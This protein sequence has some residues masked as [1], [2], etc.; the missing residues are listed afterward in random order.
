MTLKRWLPTFLAFPLGGL[1]AFET[2]GSATGPATAAAGGLLAGA[3]IGVGQWL[4]LR[5]EGVDRRWPLFTAAAMTA[6][7]ALAAAATGAGTEVSDLVLTGAVAG[8]AVGAAQSALLLGSPRVGRGHRGQLGA[9]V[10]DLGGRAG[11]AGRRG[12]RRLRLQRRAGRHRA[13]RPGAPPRGAR[14]SLA[15]RRA[16]RPADRLQRARSGCSRRA[17]TTPTS[18]ASPPTRCSRASATGGRSLVLLW[19]AF[20]LTALAAR[21]GGGAAVALDRRRRRHAAR[22]RRPSTGVL[23]ALV[24]FL[25]LVRWPFLVPYLARVAA[26]PGASEARREAVDVVFQAFNR[27]LGVAVGEHL[28]Y[29]LT[30]AW[31]IAR[32][33]RAHPDRPP[34][35]A[36]SASSASSSARCSRSARSSSSAAVRGRGWK[37]AERLTPIAYVAWSLWLIATGVALLWR[38]GAATRAGAEPG[39]GWCP[40]PAGGGSAPGRARRREREWGWGRAR[41]CCRRRPGAC[42]GPGPGRPAG[43]GRRARGAGAGSVGVSGAG[44]VRVVAAVV[45][46][47]VGGVGRHGRTRVLDHDRRHVLAR[48]G[49]GARG[50]LLEVGGAVAVGVVEAVVDAVAVGVGVSDGSAPAST[51][52][53][54]RRPSWSRVLVAVADAVAVAVRRGSARCGCAPRCGWRGRRRRSPRWRR[55]R[56]R[57]RGRSGA[58]RRR[59]CRRR[60]CP[61][62]G[63]ERR[64]ALRSLEERPPSVTVPP[65]VRGRRRPVRC[66]ASRSARRTSAT[67]RWPGRS[68]A[69]VSGVI[70]ASVP[71]L[72]RSGSRT[73]WLRSRALRA[74]PSF[75]AS[76]GASRAP[77]DDDGGDHARRHHPGEA[78]VGPPRSTPR[79]R[80]E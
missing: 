44:G 66:R 33:R 75:Q 37:L 15:G 67:R 41:A 42:P 61:A 74:A 50:L 21:A 57:G 54:L 69:K 19:W 28:G 39:R 79:A 62:L 29:L 1:L 36:G 23:A 7:S 4:A 40:G 48:A 68:A 16:D 24:Q 45:L 27:Y 46:D 22:R 9:G 3:V 78:Q 56:R 65:P 43:S 18:C 52:T 76:T 72:G 60:R 35:P 6:G 49:V 17:S 26:E 11:A 31:T 20:A 12:L 30:G 47:V 38:S 51:S 70:A 55:W 71:C 32:G 8:A 59:A 77:S 64:G 14:M 53:E 58:P 34:R 80:E 10:A 73:V 5:N 25:G 2:V 13:D 63:G